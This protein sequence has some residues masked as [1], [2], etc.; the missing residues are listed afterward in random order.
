MSVYFFDLLTNRDR[1]FELTRQSIEKGWKVVG[2]VCGGDGTV[3]WVVSEIHKYQ[4]D[5]LKLS[6]SVIPLGT[7]NDFSQ[8]F[9]W[10]K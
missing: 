1:A 10:G 4:I 2:V 7:G 5:P 8:Y 3:M 6:L 9:G